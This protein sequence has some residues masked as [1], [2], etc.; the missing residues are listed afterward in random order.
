M[1]PELNAKTCWLFS[2]NSEGIEIFDKTQERCK[3][4]IEWYEY[5]KH[6]WENIWMYRM[7]DYGAVP[8]TE[9]VDVI[10]LTEY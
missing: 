2:D 10:L 1:G 6:R 9:G 8:D 3:S 7:S 4:G 5:R